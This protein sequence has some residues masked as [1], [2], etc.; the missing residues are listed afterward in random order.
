M[1][2]WKGNDEMATDL[3][4]RSIAT[5]NV[6][7]QYIYIYVCVCVCVCCDLPYFCCLDLSSSQMA[8]F[9]LN[10]SMRFRAGFILDVNF[11]SIDGLSLSGRLK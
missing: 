11:I 6:T 10:F 7:L 2:K 3:A 5:M 8:Y 9:P 4:Q 1:K